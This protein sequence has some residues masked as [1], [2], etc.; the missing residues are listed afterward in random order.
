MDKKLII[1]LFLA[2]VQSISLDR[3]KVDGNWIE[4]DETPDLKDPIDTKKEFNQDIANLQSAVEEF[5]SAQEK[6]DQG[7]LAKDL[8]VGLAEDIKQKLVEVDKHIKFDM[9][10]KNFENQAYSD[11]RS[12]SQSENKP[13]FEESSTDPNIVQRANLMK[14]M[15]P[16]LIEMERK[17]DTLPDG[18]FTDEK[19]D[20]IYAHIENFAS[21]ETE[22]GEAEEKPKNKSGKK[23]TGKAKKSKGSKKH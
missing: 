15:I 7:G 23:S 19:L 1:A 18:S 10:P 9:N 14:K 5:T 8:A 3:M 22:E 16:N 11:D 6:M 21:S 4:V 13:S 2:S 20:N 17:L 12:L